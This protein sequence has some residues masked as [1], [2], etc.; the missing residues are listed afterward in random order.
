MKKVNN[1][2]ANKVQAKANNKVK[3]NKIDLTTIQLYDD[4][5]VTI[6]T[7]TLN[8]MKSWA[9]HTYRDLS[10]D[11]LHVGMAYED[12]KT[13]NLISY[14]EDE[15]KQMIVDAGLQ[16]NLFDPNDDDRY[17]VTGTNVYESCMYIIDICKA[18]INAL[19]GNYDAIGLVKSKYKHSELPI[20]I[21]NVY[22][23]LYDLQTRIDYKIDT[24]IPYTRDELYSIIGKAVR[25]LDDLNTYDCSDICNVEVTKYLCNEVIDI[26]N[27]LFAVMEHDDAITCEDNKTNTAIGYDEY[28]DF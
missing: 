18:Y 5:S 15:L 24:E 20:N 23:R 7:K 9:F 25:T 21:E 19:H 14:T 12:G 27:Y 28:D 13:D 22:H 1:S 26:V 2:K 4:I 6:E 10:E 3:A 8:K 17:V 16:L 11:C